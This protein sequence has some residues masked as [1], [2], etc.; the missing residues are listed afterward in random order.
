MRPDLNRLERGCAVPPPGSAA[1]GPHSLRKR[2]LNMLRVTVSDLSISNVGPVVL[3]KSESDD[4]TLPIFI[5]PPE[6]QGIVFRLNGVELP[7]P[8]T[9]D[10]FTNVLEALGA[11]LKRIEIWK[12]EEGTFYGRLV[13]SAHGKTLVIDSRPSDA[14]NLSLRTKA[15]I[16]VDEK[17]MAEAA[18]VLNETT[19]DKE[20]LDEAQ[21]SKQPRLKD[22]KGRLAQAIE[23]ERYEEA[24]MLRDQI[25]AA[26]Q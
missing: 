20:D 25:R 13:M 2:T 10:L 1:P 14:I 7:R 21:P 5:M 26:D 15:P 11:E 4:R 24:A 8:M 3:L 12:L 19:E 23:S 17:V 6:A 18:L 22:L 9:H 16:F